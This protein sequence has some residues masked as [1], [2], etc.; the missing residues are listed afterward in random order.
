MTCLSRA[1]TLVFV[2]HIRKTCCSSTHTHTQ[3]MSALVK[4]FDPILKVAARAYQGAL[5]T[6][7]NKMGLRYED[8]MSRDEPEVNEALELADP[9][10]VE[11]RYRR[12]KRA[13]D[14]A[15]KQ[16]ELQD[17][18]PD[19]ILEPFKREISADVDKILNRDL[20]FDLLNNHKKG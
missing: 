9:D 12:L 11:G 15:F 3:K 19:M 20:E 4:V 16:K 1:S 10:V 7:L 18:A 6:E 8:L 14:L 2:T 13:S 5:S 17:Y